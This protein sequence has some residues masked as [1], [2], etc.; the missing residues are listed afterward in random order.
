MKIQAFSEKHN[1]KLSTVRYYTDLGLLLPN[2]EDTYADYDSHCDDDMKKIKR[3]RSIDFS[4]SDIG[5]LMTLFRVGV[6]L[7]D[8]DVD[9]L[10]GILTHKE[11]AIHSQIKLLND[12]LEDLNILKN[13]IVSQVKLS[14]HK[15]IALNMLDYIICPLCGSYMEINSAKIIIRIISGI[16]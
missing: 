1:C 10:H 14:E 4:I 2:R 16:K 15:G 12:N 8:K 5:K 11:Q 6:V 13:E 7:S 9:V 3:L